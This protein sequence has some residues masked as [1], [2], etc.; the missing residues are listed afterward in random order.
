[1]CRHKE[2][3]VFESETN[4]CKA[5]PHIVSRCNKDNKEKEDDNKDIDGKNGT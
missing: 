2:N 1:M 4:I 5:Q 3:H